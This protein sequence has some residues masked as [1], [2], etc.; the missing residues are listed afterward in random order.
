MK[1]VVISNNHEGREYYKNA[2]SQNG[3]EHNSV[4]VGIINEDITNVQ[5]IKY[6]NGKKYDKHNSQRILRIAHFRGFIS[7]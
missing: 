4:E 5:N 2:K 3:M 6:A 1:E 7:I